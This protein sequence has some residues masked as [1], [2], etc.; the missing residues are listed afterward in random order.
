MNEDEDEDESITPPC[1]PIVLL[2]GGEE[3]EQGE[4][5]DVKSCEF[6]VWND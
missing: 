2:K 6:C 4:D 5:V 3:A 1:D